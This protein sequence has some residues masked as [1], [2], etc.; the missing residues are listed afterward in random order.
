MN[1][2]K[3]RDVINLV[4]NEDVRKLRP[5]LVNLQKFRYW[6]PPVPVTA[7]GDDVIS[8]RFDLLYGRFRAKWRHFRCFPIIA[9]H[10][11]SS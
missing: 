2:I 6:R 1:K 10:F 4:A 3:T 7:G 11:R 5:F 8:G 9:H